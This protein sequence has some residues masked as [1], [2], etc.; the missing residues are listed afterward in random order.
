[1][2]GLNGRELAENLHE[3]NPELTVLFTSGYP[4][5]TVVGQGVAESE[6]N[7]IQKPFIAEDLLP[8]VRSLLDEGKQAA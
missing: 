8:L 5:E 7:F 6:V 2:P 4:S 1:M 3:D